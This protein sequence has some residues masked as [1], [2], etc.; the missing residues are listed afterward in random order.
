MNVLYKDINFNMVVAGTNEYVYQQQ[1]LLNAFLYALGTIRRQRLFRPGYGSYLYNLLF[2]TV[3]NDT[4]AKIRI[5]IYNTAERVENG[6]VGKVKVGISDIT[7]AVT[8]NL[9]GY[10]VGITPTY[11]EFGAG[12]ASITFTVPAGTV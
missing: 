9:D 3:N 8:E 2:E 10:V 11:P 5:E 6:L 7:V 1:A 4:A 12:G